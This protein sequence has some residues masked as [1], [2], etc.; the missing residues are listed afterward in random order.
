MVA[1]RIFSRL[2]GLAGTLVVARLLTPADFGVVAVA[3]TITAATDS[4][5]EVGVQDTLIRLKGNQAHLYNAGFSIQMIR[6]LVSGLALAI[7]A[8]F[9]GQW[10]GE[11]RLKPVL[12][13]LAVVYS[14]AGLENIGVVEFRRLL[15]F[16]AEFLLSAIPRLAGFIVTVITAV[17]LRSYWALVL[18]IATTKLVRLIYSYRAHPYRP[19]FGLHGW[20]DL[21]GFTF[22]TWMSA[23]AYIVW[24]RA[25]AIIIGSGLGAAK[26]GIIVMASDVAQL[27]TS[28]LLAPIGAVLFTALAAARNDGSNPITMAFPIASMLLMILAPMA[29]IVSAVSGDLVAVLLG[30]EWRDAQTLIAILACLGLLGPFTYVS[31]VALTADSRLKLNFTIVIV[32]SMVKIALLSAAVRTGDMRLV[33]CASIG[34]AAAE[35]L[36][37]IAVLRRQGAQL[38]RVG[39]AVLRTL[40]ACAMCAGAMALSGAAWQ[41]TMLP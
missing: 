26:L 2:L 17:T 1:F 34:T 3:S 14:V 21:A 7:I 28:E 37:F 29:I 5:T 10:F 38:S 23:L 36:I 19:R 40:G 11:P 33:A 30:P 6:A 13:T 27:P 24:N 8:Q 25:D 15:R 32:S 31:S 18:G 12:L 22:W 16:N 4:V 35:G 39:M 20:R 41:A 9:A